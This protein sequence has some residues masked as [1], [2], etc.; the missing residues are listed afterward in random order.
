MRLA[1]ASLLL[2]AS[3]LSSSFPPSPS[4]PSF[5]LPTSVFPLSQDDVV[6]DRLPPGASAR[7]GSLRLRHLDS[8]R[9]VAFS[10][11]GKT[12]VSGGDDGVIRLWDPA[13]GRAIKTIR[14]DHTV[15]AVAVAPDGRIAAACVD[16]AAR[17]W[18][19]DSALIE[20]LKSDDW[21]TAIAFAPDGRLAYGGDSAILRLGKDALAGHRGRVNAVAF[22]KDGLLASAGDDGTVRLWREKPVILTGHQG[23]VLALA[24]SPDGKTLATAGRDQTVRLWPVA[25]GAPRILKGHERDVTGVAWAR[26]GKALVSSSLD[27]T[28][29]LWDVEKGTELAVVETRSAMSSVAVS[30]TLIA[31]GGLDRKIRLYDAAT[32][33]ERLTFPTH[34]GA[35]YAI[36]FLDGGVLTAGADDSARRWDATGKQVALLRSHGKTVLAAATDGKRVA[37]AGDDAEVHVW[38]DDPKRPSLKLRGHTGWI[39]SIAFLP[40]GRLVSAGYDRTVR[41]WDGVKEVQRLKGHTDHIHGVAASPDGTLIATGSEDRTVKLWDVARGEERATLRG[42]RRDVRAVAFSPDGRVLASAGFDRVVKLWDVATAKELATLSGHGGEVTSVAV[43]E[44]FIV[45]GSAD[46]TV[47]AWERRSGKEIARFA[48]EDQVR[49][50]AVDGRRVAA[51]QTDGRAL[52]WIVPA[53]ELEKGD[54]TARIEVPDTAQA[55]IDKLSASDIAVR[56]AAATELKSMGLVAEIALTRALDGEKGAEARGRME[57]VLV[58]LDRP[59]LDGDALKRTR[60]VWAMEWAGERAGLEK[61]AKEATTSRERKMAVEALKRLR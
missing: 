13:T 1:A 22:S 16:R 34:E 21:L 15:F 18:D 2:L 54:P 48:A 31:G 35:V 38:T 44:W 42:H 59:L 6:G 40:D 29:R 14:P 39:E 28:L 24:F 36:A 56:D 20:T 12:L 43:S 8:V 47:R 61:I 26:G 45:S 37:T 51:G 50:V 57:A 32:L 5:R 58:G 3:S 46:K 27:R 10:A 55:L 49:C 19:A 23:Y 9:S 30:D 60:T 25:G 17:L 7:F 4:S 33:E 11:D 53:I 41:I 52:V